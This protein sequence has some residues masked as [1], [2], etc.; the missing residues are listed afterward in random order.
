MIFNL[1]NPFEQDKYLNYTKQLFE[2]KAIVE[3]KKKHPNRSLA[4]NRYFYLL[5]G[6]FACETGYSVD[7]VKIDIFKRLCNKDWFVK[8][9]TNKRGVE[10]EYLRSSSELDTDEMSICIDR[11]RKYSS[12]QGI[13]LP[14]ANEKDFLLYIEQQIE[15]QKEYI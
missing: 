14:S 2:Q 11:F 6:W 12:S 13:Y 10:V 9:R 3:V 7:E 8:K 1:N 4:Q 5:L 15:S